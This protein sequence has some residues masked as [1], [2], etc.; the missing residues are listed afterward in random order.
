MNIKNVFKTKNYKIIS[1]IV[2]GLLLLILTILFYTRVI[3]TS[4]NPFNLIETRRVYVGIRNLSQEKIKDYDIEGGVGF[5]SKERTLPGFNVNFSLIGTSDNSEQNP[6]LL[7]DVKIWT[8]LLGFE[9][10]LKAKTMLLNQNFYFFITDIPKIPF[11]STSSLEAMKNNWVKASIPENYFQV[12]E[13][14]SKELKNLLGRK[15]I[16]VVE[17]KY[18]N[19]TVNGNECYHYLVK[20][21]PKALKSLILDALKK[22]K[23]SGKQNGNVNEIKLQEA[24]DNFSKNFDENYQKLGDLSFDVWITKKDKILTKVKFYKEIDLSQFSPKIEKQPVILTLKL[25]GLFEKRNEK[26]MIQEPKEYKNFQEI[27]ELEKQQKEE[28]K[29]E[30]K[31]GQ[32]EEKK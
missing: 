9:V 28:Q 1:L 27:L 26:L 5:L 32:K 2:L 4:W 25:D 3:N 31:E 6:K 8:E 18:K 7:S 19:E 24:I 22:A 15:N 21:K 20:V 30:Q 12:K 17:K 14:I 11:A 16:I 10:S 29:E 13:E 23:E